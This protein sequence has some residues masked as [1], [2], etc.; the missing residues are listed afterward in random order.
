MNILTFDIEEWFHILDNGSTKTEKEWAG[1]ESRIHANVDR[2]LE[3]LAE[4]KQSATFFCLGWIC[5]RYP[6]VITKIDQCGHEIGSHSHMHQ[7]VYEQSPSQ[8]RG[9]LERSILVLED[10]IGKKVTSYRSPG[11]SLTANNYWVF[12]ILSEFGIDTDC[13]I[14]LAAR[15]HGGI[16]DFSYSKPFLIKVNGKVIREFPIN[17]YRVM[18]AKV[19]FSGGGYFRLLPYPV[20]RRMFNDLDYVMTY[21]HPRD[22]DPDQP[23]IKNL[24]LIRKFKSYYGLTNSFRKL[25]GLISEF[26]FCSLQEASSRVD[27]GSCPV[28]Q[29]MNKNGWTIA[30]A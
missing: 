19:L 27:W 6:E 13:S 4:K 2:I 11:F 1:Y 3:L 20:I 26:E 17:F 24:S 14:F 9:D 23:Y 25:K 28:F 21:F 30:P 8:F 10:T 16:R 5:E 29:T 22:F 7:L 12:D 18:G 15:A